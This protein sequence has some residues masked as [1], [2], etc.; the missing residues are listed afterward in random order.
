MRSYKGMNKKYTPSPVSSPSEM[1]FPLTVKVIMIDLDGTLLDTAGDLATA[2]NSMLRELGAA[3]LSLAT[4]K[5]YIGKGILN[6][7]RRCLASS[8]NNE[9]SPDFLAQAM[10]IYEQEYAKKLCVTTRP[11]PR[12]VDG[13]IAMKA[14]GFQL[15]CITNKSE[16][17]TL[18]LLRATELL[19]Y[20]DIVLSGDSLPKKKPDPAPLHYACKFFGILPNEMLLIG[21]SGN[22]TKAA[23]AAGSYV[24]CVPYGYNE[25]RDVHE[26]DCDRVIPSIY[27]A[28]HLI[29]RPT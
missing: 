17:F 1:E 7:V 11:Y 9:P 20:F 14:A 15:A 21:D 24:F 10:V 6:L 26:L 12:V 28:V 13:L 4:I 19:N 5:S 27:E 18:P 23:R 25:G 16:S 2:A 3:E 22:D 8:F 29:K